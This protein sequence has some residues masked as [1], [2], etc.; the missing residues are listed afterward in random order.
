MLITSGSVI[1]LVNTSIASCSGSMG[2]GVYV[3]ASSLAGMGANVTKSAA[4]VSGGG[5]FLT[6]ANSSL[7]GLA[8]RDCSAPEGGGIAA[9][10]ATQA[11]LSNVDITNNN[12]TGD[13]GGIHATQ[14]DL[15]ISNSRAANNSANYSGGGLYSSESTVVG[16]LTLA[17]NE[18]AYGG[19]AASTGI[20]ML[21][22]TV[23]ESNSAQEAGG[24]LYTGDGELTLREVDVKSCVSLNG[25]GVYLSTARL[26]HDQVRIANCTAQT[27]GGMYVDTS[28]LF[29]PVAANSSAVAVLNLNK[30]SNFGGGVYMSGNDTVLRGFRI[31]ASS[32]ISGGGIAAESSWNCT[33]ANG[34]IQNSTVTRL[35]G[36]AFFGEDA[37]CLFMSS[38]VELNSAGIAGGGIAVYKANLNHSSLVIRGNQGKNGGGLFLSNNADAVPWNDRTF[39]RS[40]LDANLAGDMSFNGANVQINCTVNCVLSGFRITRG[41]VWSG[42]GGGVYISGKGKILLTGLATDSNEADLGGGVFISD[43]SDTTIRSCSFTS[44]TAEE[45]GG[46]LNIENANSAA[47][48]VEISDSVFYNNTAGK[49]G[50]GAIYLENSRLAGSSLLVLEN[51]ATHPDLGNGGGAYAFKKSS[52]SVDSS[53]FLL[54]RARLGGS[55]AVT[56][57]SEASIN[58][59]TI[60][61][62]TKK[63]TSAWVAMFQRLVGAEYREKQANLDFA[64]EGAQKGDLVYLSG[65]NTQMD[66]TNSFLTNG[67]A[68]SGGGASVEDNAVLTVTGSKFT[69]NSAN[70]AGGSVFLATTASVYFTLSEISASSECLAVLLVLLGAECL[71]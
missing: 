54:N 38:V 36:G 56:S 35:G 19:G 58:G 29:M 33:I 63:V 65:V 30:A 18:A 17:F 23:L 6:G 45:R 25:G 53:L 42:R 48:T 31:S 57:E 70:E 32:A 34:L 14:C 43:A 39:Q 52:L 47:T 69:N 1:Q 51:R 50:G 40:L 7:S 46:G 41:V 2:A 27:G 15:T 12:V 64:F 44:N 28:S 26:F 5:V 37:H 20:T 71:L 60:T 24:G 55:F 16:T 49:E 59:S 67:S 11:S 4:A 61:G 3:D 9:V 13:G 68:E 8:I 21:A 10:Q 66:I 62:D 22:N